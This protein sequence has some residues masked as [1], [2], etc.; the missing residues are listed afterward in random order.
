MKTEKIE[1][2][3]YSDYICNDVIQYCLLDYIYSKS[4]V[5]LKNDHDNFIVQEFETRFDQKYGVFKEFYYKLNDEVYDP[6]YDDCD[7]FDDYLEDNCKNSLFTETST[8]DELLKE[9][10]E[11]ENEVEKRK[12]THV[13]ITECSY[14]LSKYYTSVLDGDY[15]KYDKDNGKLLELKQYKKGKL[16][17]KNFTYFDENKIKKE[18]YYSEEGK[19]IGDYREYNWNGQIIKECT[20]NENEKLIGLYREYTYCGKNI[21]KECSYN[22]EGKLDGEFKEYMNEFRGE[23]IVPYII[24]NYKNGEL[25]GDYLINYKYCDFPYIKTHYLNGK[26]NGPFI[27]YFDT[28]D[29][30]FKTEYK[31]MCETNY[32]ENKLHGL[33]KEFFKNG[34]LCKQI[35]YYDGVIN[36][37][38]KEYDETGNLIL[39]CDFVNGKKHGY[40]ID[41]KNKGIGK[42]INDIQVE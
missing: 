18:S 20:Y 3:L 8:M 10:K 19:L 40:L 32:K 37:K 9:V 27:K 16:C 1:L 33:H 17:G 30:I 42:F 36:G 39:E 25:C 34:R 11:V 13:L 7:D 38:H 12:I 21:L 35:D 41:H 15:K 2:S 31:M 23:K 14:T 4:T 24:C 26:L 22:K 6:D 28:Y 5:V 29:H